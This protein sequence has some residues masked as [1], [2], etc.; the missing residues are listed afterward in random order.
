[1]SPIGTKIHRNDE[2]PSPLRY[3]P[4]ASIIKNKGFTLI[5]L[6]LVVFL[7]S[8]LVALSTPLFKRTFTDLQLRNT[9]YNVTKTINYAR[10]MAIIERSNY[11]INFNFKKGEYWITRLHRTGEKSIYKRTGGRYGRIF[12]LPEGIYFNARDDEMLFYPDGRAEEIELKIYGK[13]KKGYLLKIKSFGKGVE[14]RKI[15]ASE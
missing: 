14:L 13:D 2:R 4:C 10:E 6:V 7:I 8:V 9:V 1:M 11:K 12:S 5:E 3:L 15:D